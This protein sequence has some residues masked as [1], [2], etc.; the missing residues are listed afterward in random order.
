MYSFMAGRLVFPLYKTH[1]TT[2]IQRTT[3][4]MYTAGQCNRH[5]APIRQVDF[6][7]T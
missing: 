5:I 1:A 4:I 3:Y 6:L 2:T 7:C